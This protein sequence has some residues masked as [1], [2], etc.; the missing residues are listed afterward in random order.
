MMWSSQSTAETGNTPPDRACRTHR[1]YTHRSFETVTAQRRKGQTARL[2]Q[3]WKKTISSGYFQSTPS[4][5]ERGGETLPRTTMSGRTWSWSTQSM[6]P[7]RANPVCTCTTCH[8]KPAA[9][10]GDLVSNEEDIVLLADLGDL[11]Q[12]PCTGHNHSGLPLQ[13]HN[14]VNIPNF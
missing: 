10:K 13:K 6:R 7:V 11:L 3:T 4:E 2:F 14:P 9:N 1:I 8:C 12:I 5:R